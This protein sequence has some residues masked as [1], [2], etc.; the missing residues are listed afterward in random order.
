MQMHQRQRLLE[1]HE[2]ALGVASGMSIGPKA[3]DDGPL[4]G[5][6]RFTERDVALRLLQRTFSVVRHAAMLR[7]FTWSD[8][9]HCFGAP[10][11]KTVET[12]IVAT[13]PARLAIRVRSAMWSGR[14][15]CV[16]P[17]RATLFFL[18]SP[19]VLLPP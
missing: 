19:R 4:L 9:R 16:T 3:R 11:R 13:G 5:D 15:R 2:Q 6:K 7:R 18:A 14:R 8:V 17:A 12:T 10:N 1:R